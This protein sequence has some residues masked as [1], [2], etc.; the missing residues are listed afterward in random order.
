M[1]DFDSFTFIP[2]HSQ[3]R[4]T[5]CISFCIPAAVLVETAI[6]SANPLLFGLSPNTV[7][8]PTPDWRRPIRSALKTRLKSSG[9]RMSPCFVPRSIYTGADLP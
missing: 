1:T 2:D 5:T 7:L 6:S 9:D 3:K 8:T 4:E